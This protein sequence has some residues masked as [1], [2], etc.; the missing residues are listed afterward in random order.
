MCE[1]QEKSMLNNMIMYDQVCWKSYDLK[2]KKK[3]LEYIYFG[4]IY[5]SFM[6][7]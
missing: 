6:N 5:S 1:M 3:V 4:N 7:I 2:K